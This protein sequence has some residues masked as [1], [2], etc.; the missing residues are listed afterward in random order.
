MA[1]TW[2]DYANLGLNVANVALN[3]AQLQSLGEINSQLAQLSQLEA[4]RER[5]RQLENTLRQFVFE[6]ETKLSGLVSASGVTPT[7][8]WFTAMII[9]QN[10]D[11]VSVSASSFQEFVDKDRVTSFRLRLVQVIEESQQHLT[12][13]ELSSLQQVLQILNERS[14]LTEYITAVQAQEYLEY[15][16]GQWEQY[17]QFEGQSTLG[18]ILLIPLTVILYGAG[19]F[20]AILSASLFDESPEWLSIVVM[21]ALML[22]LPTAVAV[23]VYFK[24]YKWYRPKTKGLNE[25]IEKRNAA[26]TKIPPAERLQVLGQIFGAN[27]TSEDLLS[28]QQRREQI[29]VSTV[30][31]IG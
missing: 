8:R 11:S 10:L 5:R 4:D 15:T 28:E 2:M 26:K 3:S 14:A 1:N 27:V 22:I 24:V 13:G 9:Q 20:L 7:K 25:M 31:M 29:L 30:S 17:R 12:G 16:R 6:E 21:L 23:Y 19:S 18:C